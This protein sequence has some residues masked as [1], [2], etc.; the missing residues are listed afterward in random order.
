MVFGVEMLFGFVPFKTGPLFALMFAPTLSFSCCLVCSPT[1]FFSPSSLSLSQGAGETQTPCGVW[2]SPS[3]SS[4]WPR[5][6]SS[7][8]TPCSSPSPRFPPRLVFFFFF[9]RSRGCFGVVLAA[10]SVCQSV[11]LLSCLALV[12]AFD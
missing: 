3:V 10:F 4:S 2:G 7:T 8:R 5:T 11:C 6:T 1:T 9:R 12:H